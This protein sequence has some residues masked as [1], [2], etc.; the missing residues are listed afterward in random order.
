MSG[1]PVRNLV[2]VCAVMLTSATCFGQC[3]SAELSASCIPKL[4]DTFKFL[5]T[6]RVDGDKAIKGKIEYSYI[7]TKGTTYLI[8][9]YQEPN[10][11]PGVIV[12]LFD[13][14]RHLVAT[15]KVKEELL[16]ALSYSCEA[17]GIFYIQYTFSNHA[18][19]QCAGSALGFR[20]Q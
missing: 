15:T 9:L 1:K 2:I 19:T 3:N 8:N 11:V 12:T 14:Q 20:R 16:S 4:G 5:K 10:A 17:T 18:S 13:N 7:L 6:Y